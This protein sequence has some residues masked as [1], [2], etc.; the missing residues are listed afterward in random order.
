MLLSARRVALRLALANAGIEVGL[1]A[2]DRSKVVG[3][4]LTT[5]V[6]LQSSCMIDRRSEDDHG[7]GAPAGP[8][9]DLDQPGL[10]WPVDVGGSV[11]LP[12]AKGLILTLGD[13]VGPN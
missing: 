12:E 7:I 11:D 6:G 2:S 9:G 10:L 1:D 13:L 4:A 8:P 3:G 5:G